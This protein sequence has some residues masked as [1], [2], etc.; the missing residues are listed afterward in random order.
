M[1]KIT[2]GKAGRA[3]ASSILRELIPEID[4]RLQAI[5]RRLDAIQADMRAGEAKFDNLRDE[6]LSRFDQQ[7]DVINELGERIARLDGRLD[8]FMT[9]VHRQSDKMDQWI[10]RLVKIEMTQASRKRRAG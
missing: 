1:G 7:R 3:A 5:E 6:M 8:G 2:L 4:V 10:E 9:S